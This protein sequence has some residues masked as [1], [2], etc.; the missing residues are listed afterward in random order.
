[1]KSISST[2]SRVGS[3]VQNGFDADVSA[4][5]SIDKKEQ[6][7]AIFGAGLSN[8]EHELSVPKIGQPPRQLQALTEM[9]GKNVTVGNI[10][11]T[12]AAL[13]DM[14]ALQKTLVEHSLKLEKEDRADCLAAILV[15]EDA[16]KLR[17]RLQQM[18]END[19]EL[20]MAM[21]ESENKK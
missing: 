16:V 10:A 14:R 2:S 4:I 5:H 11:W 12:P 8:A 9:L 18:R 19:A 3:S 21:E 20:A 7:D 6:K 1:M 15:V 13:P 17:L